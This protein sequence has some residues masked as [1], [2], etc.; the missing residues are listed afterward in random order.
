MRAMGSAIRAWM[1]STCEVHVD[2]DERLDPSH[3]ATTIRSARATS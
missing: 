2:V 3:G 1:T